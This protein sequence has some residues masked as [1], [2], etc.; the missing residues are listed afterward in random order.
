M[1]LSDTNQYIE[2]TISSVTLSGVHVAVDYADHTSRIPVGGNENLTVTGISAVKIVKEPPSGKQRQIKN[3]TI[4]NPNATTIGVTVSQ[5]YS[6][7]SRIR[8]VATIGSGQ[9]LQYSMNLG[10][11]VVDIQ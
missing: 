7:T 10:W 11:A 9:T 4:Y 2:L 3:I 8:K 5:V 1:F 6:G